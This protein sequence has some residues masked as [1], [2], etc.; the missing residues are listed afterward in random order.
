MIKHI[1]TLIWNK[2]RKN[3]LLFLEIF[4]AFA[5]LFAVFTFAVQSFRSYSSPLGFDTEDN[6]IAFMEWDQDLDST[7]LLDMKLRL[8]RELEDKPQ[9][10]SAAY[11]GNITP[12]SG[13]TWSTTTDDNGFELS[14]RLVEGDE[15]YLETAGVNV[16][17]GRHFNEDDYNAKYQAII[18]NQLLVESTFGDKPVLD[19]VILLNGEKKVVGIIDHFK[20]MGEFS[21]EAN[22][23]V[24]LKPKSSRD[25][26]NL[27]MRLAP[28]TPADFE[29]EVNRTISEIT[30]R[31]DFIIQNLDAERIEE[32]RDTWVPLIASLCICAFLIIN[33]ALG[34]FGVL[35]YTISKRRAEIGLRRTLGATKAVISRQF[36]GEVL[37]VSGAAL[38]IGIFFA[39]QLP[40][41][42]VM[43]IDDINYYLS[44]GFTSVLILSVVLL[45]AFYPSRQAANIHP[46]MALHEE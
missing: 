19:S 2:R 21:E 46:A 39:I 15:D 8:E 41:M 9:I 32:S 20:Y 6:W 36:V 24:S 33:V 10:I 7:A 27:Q 37:L 5:V 14:T 26:G 28:G 45:C 29:A 43:D 3:F 40:L 44:I 34:L 13:S 42:N 4:L 22:L 38:L 1:F 23:T 18:F 11:V 12:F 16:I 25:L 17:K 31:N 35:Y 30:K